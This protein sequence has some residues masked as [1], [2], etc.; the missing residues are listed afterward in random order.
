MER[1]VRRQGG[2][3][4]VWCWAEI[5]GWSLC[6]CDQITVYSTH[7]SDKSFVITWSTSD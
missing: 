2:W 1:E 5:G 4:R 6:I 3:V 7:S